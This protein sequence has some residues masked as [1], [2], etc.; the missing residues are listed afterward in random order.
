MEKSGGDAKPAYL[1]FCEE[2]H[3]VR[4]YL[5]KQGRASRYL[6]I[7]EPEHRLSLREF[8]DT[9]TELFRKWLCEEHVKRWYEQPAAWLDEI[10]KRHTEYSWI[11]HFI[12]ELDG[13]PIGFGQFY[14][15]SRGGEAWHGSTDIDGAFSIDYLIGRPDCIGKGHGREIIIALLS[16]VAVQPNA[17]LVIVRP[18]PENKA[19]C[20]ALLSAGFQ[21]DEHNEL[22]RYEL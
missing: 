8:E 9:D 5:F 20:A 19:S 15:Y 21:Y 10:D 11:H 14:E 4:T 16:K 3:G 13:V 22:Y 17:R 2:V 12:A 7:S 18:E 6:N 1:D